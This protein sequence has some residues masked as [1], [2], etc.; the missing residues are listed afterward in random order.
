LGPHERRFRHVWKCLE[1]QRPR[2]RLRLR[3]GGNRLTAKVDGATVQTLTYNTGNQIFTTGYAFDA[4]GNR[5]TDPN[6]GTLT[7][8][9]AGQTTTRTKSGTTT[10][11]TWAGGDQNE[12]V[13]TTTG[14]ASASY[15]YGRTDHNGVPTMESFTKN[16]QTS[17]LDTDPTGTPIALTTGTSVD[18]YTLDNQGSPIGLVGSGG[19]VA[20]TYTYDPAGRQT[21]ATGTSLTHPARVA[22]RTCSSTA[23]SARTSQVPSRELR[24]PRGTWSVNSLSDRLLGMLPGEVPVRDGVVLRGLRYR[25]E[26]DQAPVVLSTTPY[27]ADR[28]HADGKYFAARGFNYITLDSRGRGDSTG[29]F[30]PFVNDGVDGYDAV[31]WLAQQS[32]STGQ[33]V[34]HGGSYGGFVQWATAATNPPHLCTIAPVASVYP[35]FDFPMVRNIGSA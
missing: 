17:Y 16:G 15:V 4:A 18:F 23:P 12:L 1:L 34:L 32:W 25:P 5:T 21:S 13:S 30:E 22:E 14:S 7:Y 35:G 9:A 29:R 3:Q 2:L 26:V 19:T 6:Q 8:N 24:S 27:G 31:E 11:Y 28:F 10:S 33:I 20:A